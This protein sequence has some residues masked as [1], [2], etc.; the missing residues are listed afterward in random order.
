M[1][2]EKMMNLQIFN[3]Q[4]SRIFLFPITTLNTSYG[5]P[6]NFSLLMSHSLLVHTSLLSPHK[7][8]IWLNS[9]LQKNLIIHISA[10]SRD[11][12]DTFMPRGIIMKTYHGMFMECRN[13]RKGLSIFDN[14]FHAYYSMRRLQ[15]YSIN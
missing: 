11:S 14:V 13:I 5:I 7:W 2:F 10:F 9:S 3:H 8:H 1:N 6:V 15:K 4:I 12:Q